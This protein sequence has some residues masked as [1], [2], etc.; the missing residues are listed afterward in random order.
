MKHHGISTEEY[1]YSMFEGAW[2]QRSLIYPFNM[3]NEPTG[4]NQ[5]M[6][7]EESKHGSYA[8]V[9]PLMDSKG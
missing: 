2:M 6:S 1:G 9:C 5:H 8:C 3:E 7:L 4:L